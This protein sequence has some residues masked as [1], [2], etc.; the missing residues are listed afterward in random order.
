MQIKVTQE[1]TG[2]CEGV[3]RYIISACCYH[4][5]VDISFRLFLINSKDIN[6]RGLSRNGNIL[7]PMR[8]IFSHT[9]Q[10]T[11]T[12]VFY[13]SCRPL[14]VRVIL[15]VNLMVPATLHKRNFYNICT[16]SLYLITS[17]YLF[18][19]RTQC[20]WLW[21]RTVEACTLVEGQRMAGGVQELR[22]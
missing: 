6:C 22:Q 13:L 21:S 7:T 16:S 18:I 19:Q 8:R 14:H 10:L 9:V 5:T 12:L 3:L 1:K 11:L 4:F 20:L 2:R 17:R 15:D